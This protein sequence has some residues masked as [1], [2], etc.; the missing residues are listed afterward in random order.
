MA[1]SG[2]DHLSAPPAG[3]AAPAAPRPLAGPGPDQ[4]PPSRPG[5][6]ERLA[7]ALERSGAGGVL[8]RGP[9]WR[10]VIVLAYHRIGDGSAAAVDRE[11]WSAT[12]E[13]LDRQLRLVKRH[14]EI[15]GPDQLIDGTSRAPGRRVMITFD[16]GY[17]DLYDLAFAVLTANGVAATMFLCPGFI[18]GLV[19]AWWDEI[20]WMIRKSERV[21]LPAG[22]WSPTPLAQFGDGAAAT[23]ERVNQAYR[24]QPGSRCERFLAQLGEATGSGRR[25]TADRRADWITWDQAREMQ[26]AGHEIGAHTLS[27]PLLAR[28]LPERQ[29]T[30]ISGSIERIEQQLGRR[31]RCFCYPVGLRDTFSTAT[32]QCLREE[33]IEL[34]FTDY[35]GYVAGRRLRPYDVRR[36][37]IGHGLSDAGFAAMLT[38]PQV[39]AR[40]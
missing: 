29:R 37:N 7:R 15:V 33:G 31:P 34:A 40:G 12:A 26:A 11:L 16:D 35:G 32:Q 22:P 10:G 36:T 24:A 17:H 14:F 23:I 19:S 9:L 38:V 18:D 20:A 4:A 5:K 27:H 25:P 21:D 30:E 6:R 3:S 28:C 39:F 8:R 2:A 1:L 13:Q